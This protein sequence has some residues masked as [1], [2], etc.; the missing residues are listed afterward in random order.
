V[1]SVRHEG[2]PVG[3]RG[4]RAWALVSIAAAGLTLAGCSNFASRG[5]NA[6]G[7]RLFQ[8]SQYQPAIQQFQQAVYADPTNADSYYNMAAVY[9]QTGKLANRRADLD[10]A[11]NLYNQCLD[12]DPEHKDCYRGLAVL[13]VE[14]G[15][16][17]EAFRLVQGWC[18]RQPTSAEARIEIA[19]LYEEFGDQRSA[20]QRLSE[21]LTLDP[22]NARALA[23]IG[24]LR[25]QSG[26]QVQAMANYQRSLF[27]NRF[28]PEVAARLAALQTATGTTA[29]ATMPDDVGRLVV[30]NTN[31]RK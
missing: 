19:R 10:Q 23:A 2:R 5:M 26:D 30:R 15:R 11:E 24:K 9:H 28:Q 20:M 18:D 6:E 27:I 7:V 4:A 17:T 1:T 21:A 22:N 16:T 8:Q 14:E 13:L 3:R 25:E 12:R 31:P 29:S